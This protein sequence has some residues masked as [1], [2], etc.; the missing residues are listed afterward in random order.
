MP[1]FTVTDSIDP[2]LH[3]A[4][5][6]G[7]HIYSESGAMVMMDAN[8]EL[9]GR[10][11]GGFWRALLQSMFNR[12]SF[13]RQQ[14]QATNGKG[15]CLLAPTLPGAIQVIDIGAHQYFLNDGAFMATTAEVV[16][17]VRTQSF[18]KALF[19]KSGGF[20]VMETSGK[21]QIVV[22]GFGSITAL[23]V[24]AGQ[25]V[26]IDNAHVVC[27]DKNLTYKITTSTARQT[28]GA[29]GVIGKFANSVKSGEGIV[30][31]FSGQGKVYICSR[32]PRSFARLV[33]A[34]MPIK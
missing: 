27:W 26:I 11:N 30:L 4:L 28:K 23:T 20:F 15:T 33:H 22:A 21:G 25:D 5:Q 18:S 13:F 19:G 8:L 3:V 1:I 16:L 12:E 14:I 32:N 24:E 34:I 7:E 29:R 9:T 2:F 6:Q 31:R 17:Q 10:M